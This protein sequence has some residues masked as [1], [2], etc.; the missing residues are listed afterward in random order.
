MGPVIFI[1]P[2]LKTSLAIQLTARILYLGTN[3]CRD[4]FWLLRMNTTFSTKRH[5]GGVMCWPWLICFRR[6]LY[7][8]SLCLLN[9]RKKNSGSLERITYI[10]HFIH[11]IIL[12]LWF[13]YSKMSRFL[14]RISK[15]SNIRHQKIFVYFLTVDK[16]LLFLVNCKQLLWGGRARNWL[17]G[18]EGWEKSAS[19]SYVKCHIMMLT[20]CCVGKWNYKKC[21][22]KLECKRNQNE[23][24]S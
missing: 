2:T 23:Q 10:T 18:D 11:G 12:P 9:L 8:A 24:C 21:I 19:Y 5:S 6:L 20:F 13:C 4:L 16:I 7:F 3:K 1:P 14:F 17:S 15:T 22:K